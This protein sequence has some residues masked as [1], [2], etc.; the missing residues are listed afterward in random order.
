MP[1]CKK[2]NNKW[3][4]KQTINKTT[5]LD[6]EMICPYCG[7]KQ[8]QSKKSKVVGAF[9]S[10]IILLPLL[11]QPFFNIPVTVLLSLIPVLVI[12]IFFVYPFTVKLSNREESTFLKD[13]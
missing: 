4:F 1:I 9:L 6:S 5:T 7:K 10:L 11:I 3:S 13:K 8:Y 2:C 12:I